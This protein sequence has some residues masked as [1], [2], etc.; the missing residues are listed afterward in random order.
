MAEKKIGGRTFRVGNVLATEAIKLQLRLL[1]IVGGGVDRLP[2]ILAG[3]G[4]KGEVDAEAKAA[5]DAAAVAA[6]GDIFSKCDPDVVTQ[7]ISDIVEM[8]QLNNPSGAWE[9]V[10]I[11]QD[12]TQK[13]G[14]L[15]PVII[16]VLQEVLGDFFSGSQVNGNLK[17]FLDKAGA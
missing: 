4:K 16:F 14:D 10:N 12:F 15:F 9:T 1:K 7:I 2:T 13:K 11:D 6:L 3:M 17:K 5:S 8:A